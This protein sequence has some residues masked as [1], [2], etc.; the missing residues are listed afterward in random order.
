LDAETLDEISLIEAFK[1]LGGGR[2]TF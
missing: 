1:L 2:A